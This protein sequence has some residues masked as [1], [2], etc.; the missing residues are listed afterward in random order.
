[1]SIERLDGEFDSRSFGERRSAVLYRKLR[2]FLFSIVVAAAPILIVVL[3]PPRSGGLFVAGYLV[4]GVTAPIVV[5][6]ALKAADDLFDTGWLNS[7]LGVVI[8][9]TV[10]FLLSIAAMLWSFFVAG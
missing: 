2:G 9:L 5:L 3:S 10:V 8:F 1:M 7:V 6:G 4:G